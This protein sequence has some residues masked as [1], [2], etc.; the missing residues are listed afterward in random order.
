MTK[1]TKVFS[2]TLALVLTVL[3]LVVAGIF[4]ITAGAEETETKSGTWGGVDWTLTPD[5]KLTI[6]PT[7]GTPTTDNSGKWTYEVGQWPEAVVY[8]KNGGASSIGGY[9][10]D[11]KAVKKLKLQLKKAGYQLVGN[12]VQ[13]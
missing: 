2:R 10:Y 4:V 6:A 5:G 13:R 8:N 11:V 3:M 12:E 1:Q 7:T 9:P